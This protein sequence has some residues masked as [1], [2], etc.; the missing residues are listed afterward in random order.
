MRCAVDI[1]WLRVFLRGE[2]YRQLEQNRRRLLERTFLGKCAVSVI[3]LATLTSNHANASSSQCTSASIHPT[4]N[5]HSYLWASSIPH[6][7]CIL[8]MD[9]VYSN[10]P[11]SNRRNCIFQGGPPLRQSVV[12]VYSFTKNSI[13]NSFIISRIDYCN[14]LLAGAP[15]YQLDRLQSVLNTAARLLIGAK[16]HDHIKHVLLDRLHWL[17]VPSDGQ[18]LT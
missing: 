2:K 12:T 6:P 7:T 8:Y 18:K 14:S 5:Y 15:R 17:P 4:T 1:R 10:R 9:T 3:L 16:K 13:V 11:Y